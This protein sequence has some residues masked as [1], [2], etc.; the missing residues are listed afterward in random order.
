MKTAS[1]LLLFFSGVAMAQSAGVFTKSGNLNTARDYHTATLLPNGKVLI[2]GGS[3]VFSDASSIALASA[4]LYDPSTGT[5]AMAG[6]MTVAR[7]GHT[8]TS[9]ANGKNTNMVHLECTSTW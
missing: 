6:N 7:A 9:L 3:T 4:E 1:A 5:F 8:A 2:A